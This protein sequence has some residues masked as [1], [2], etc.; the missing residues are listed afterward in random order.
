M[1]QNSHLKNEDTEAQT[2]LVTAE[3]HRACSSQSCGLNLSFWAQSAELFPYDTFPWP[4]NLWCK[5]SIEY[6]IKENTIND[7]NNQLKCLTT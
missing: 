6:A 1:F 4:P 7:I 2:G 5:P 3:G